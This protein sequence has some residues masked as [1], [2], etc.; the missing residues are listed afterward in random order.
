MPAKRINSGFRD[1]HQH[2]ASARLSY[3]KLNR[4]QRRYIQVLCRRLRFLQQRV[5]AGLETGEDRSYD[6][7]EASALQWLL[8]HVVPDFIE[9][10]QAQRGG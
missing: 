9:S 6:R 4:T 8:N 10:K 7:A 3:D 5:G 2:H 1:Q